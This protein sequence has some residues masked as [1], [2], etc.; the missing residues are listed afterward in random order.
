MAGGSREHLG[1]AEE[2]RRNAKSVLSG[3]RRG[4]TIQ[5]KDIWGKKTRIS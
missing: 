4:R 1:K 2:K 5:E 3:T